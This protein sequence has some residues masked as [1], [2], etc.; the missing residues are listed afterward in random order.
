MR[1]VAGKQ[2]AGNPRGYPSAESLPC[3]PWPAMM[4]ANGGNFPID[5]KGLGRLA[6]RGSYPIAHDMRM[7]AG[8]PYSGPIWLGDMRG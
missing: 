6:E 4:H 3:T 5:R 7:I 1:G 8:T 2:P